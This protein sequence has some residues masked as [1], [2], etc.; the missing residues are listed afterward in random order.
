MRGFR[1]LL[2]ASSP[3]PYVPP[4]GVGIDPQPRAKE[5]LVLRVWLFVP[6]SMTLFAALAW[7]S[8]PT[9]LLFRTVSA[10]IGV[11]FIVFA[12]WR[13][14]YQRFRLWFLLAAIAFIALVL[15][16]MQM[17]IRHGWSF[18]VARQHR[19]RAMA[20]EGAQGIWKTKP[21]GFP[22]NTPGLLIPMLGEFRETLHIYNRD[23]ADALMSW[24][25]RLAEKYGKAAKRPWLAIATDDPP[26]G[27]ETT[28]RS[29]LK[30][31][32][33]TSPR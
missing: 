23:E 30:P 11:F 15:G 8:I 12:I 22:S 28:D 26:P 1:R 31:A 20:I 3:F 10:S 14:G 5:F 18:E 29:K 6:G 2:F 16:G 4:R 17:A 32:A 25:S 19:G 21:G 9:P 7:S 27:D 13:P 24:H 33:A